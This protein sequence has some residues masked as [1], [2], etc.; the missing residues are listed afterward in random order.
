MDETAVV[1][2]A[3]ETVR[4]LLATDDR[5]PMDVQRLAALYGELAGHG[6][7]LIALLEHRYPRGRGLS[8]QERRLID[9]VGAYVCRSAPV[10]LDAAAIVGLV[11]L[12][13]MVQDLA[14]LVELP[15][16]G[17]VGAGAAG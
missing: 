3:L 1:R 5:V 11:Q 7:A 10:G 2:D 12:A 14:L 4:A 8:G 9:R 16:G 6:R 13:E 15:L 17:G